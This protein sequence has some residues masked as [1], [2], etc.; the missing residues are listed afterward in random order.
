[1]STT[2]CT[3][4]IDDDRGRRVVAVWVLLAWNELVC[5]GAGR[6]GGGESIAVDPA[7]MAERR[8]GALAREADNEERGRERRGKAEG[9]WGRW[10]WAEM[11]GWVRVVD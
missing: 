3:L 11:S 9:E 6:T 8:S 7:G 4:T 5:R 10:C 2:S 1:M